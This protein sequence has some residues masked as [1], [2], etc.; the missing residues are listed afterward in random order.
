MRLMIARADGVTAPS[1]RAVSRSSLLSSPW[2]AAVCCCAA[3]WFASSSSSS[4]PRPP[5]G[6]RGDMGWRRHDA[7]MCFSKF[8][9]NVLYNFLKATEQHLIEHLSEKT[10]KSSGNIVCIGKIAAS[11]F[12]RLFFNGNGAFS[13]SSYDAF[14]VEN[15]F[16]S[17]VLSC[18]CNFY[19]CKPQTW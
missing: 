4:P 8:V 5:A 18:L 11:D 17:V 6:E 1:L 12:L 9:A 10:E 14:C 13:I 15:K 3:S 19:E 2:P 16:L 7:H